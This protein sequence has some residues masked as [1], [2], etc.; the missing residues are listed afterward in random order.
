MQSKSGVAE[1]PV[2]PSQATDELVRRQLNRILTSRSF[3]QVDRLQRFLAFI[4]E[5]TLS[6]RG[7][8]L[9]E[10]PIGVDV[11]A[12]SSSFDPRMD[13]IVRVQAR[14]LRIR[15]ASYYKDEGQ[16]DDLMIE[17]P[18]GGYIPIFR[19]L[20]TA[21]PKRPAGAVLVSRN[22]VMVLPFE[23]DSPA[24]DQA[25]FCKGLR[26]QI[27]YSLSKEDS[28]LLVSRDSEVESLHGATPGAALVVSGSVRKCRDVLRITMHVT[29]A[30]R[31][32]FLWSESIDRN[33]GDVFSVQE[34]VAQ[35]VQHT[36]CSE[37]LDGP[38]RKPFRRH[39]EN[40]AAHNMYLQG[41]Y[42]LDQRTEQGLRKAM[43]FFG[44]AITEDPQL[45][46]AFAGLADAHNLLAHYGVLAPADVWTKAASN[47]AQAV[48]LDDDSAEAHTSLAHVKATQDW[49]WAAAERE[50]LRA[51]S[52][53]PR[54]PTAHHWYAV[55][56]LAP[57]GRLELAMEEM[58][59]AQAL[60][61]V[62]SIIGRD[63]AIIHYYQRNFDLALEQCDHAIE[64]NPHFSAGYWTLGLVQEQRADYEE[65]IAAF[66]RAIELSPPSPR[67]LGALG[68]IYAR[69]G[70]KP[71]AMGILGELDALAKRR[72]I[73][74]F[75]LALIYFAL[76]RKEEAFER[77]AKAY[78][79]RCFEL[80]TIKVDPRFDSV[81]TDPRFTS[82]FR[83]LGLP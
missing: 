75:E 2:G 41:R 14:R 45:A 36:V 59:M 12:K 76:D 20:E 78:Q 24:G 55:S 9:K 82:L 35:M 10:Y 57:L 46:P 81:R 50:F 52:L 64:Q 30:V 63:I 38:D 72:Y 15:L 18:K 53:N 33:P 74:P 1:P 29:D 61:P 26:H 47:A 42:H 71:E 37:M 27:V 19:K 6:G 65:A 66:Q 77:L 21:A 31:G 62:S 16:G 44:R 13:P 58:L 17:L 4:V 28:I 79:D 39:T 32:C 83:Q 11:F 5:E 7:D 40:L 34:E 80:I 54:Y 67:I 49:D 56:C 8:V 70:R 43:D 68:R 22:T 25:Y 69:S 51:I 23:D 3:R 48:I 73:S 60:D